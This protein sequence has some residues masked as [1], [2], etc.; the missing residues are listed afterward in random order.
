MSRAGHDPNPQSRQMAD[1]SMVRTLAAQAAAIW[2][3][4][5]PLFARYALPPAARILDVGCGTGEITRRLLLMHPHAT[6]VGIDVLDG[7]L[8]IARRAHADLAPRV[9][10][11]RGDAFHLQYADAS[12]DLVTCRHVIQSVPHPER[13]L[14]ECL[15]VTKHGGWLHVLAEDYG[16]LQFPVDPRSGLDPDE[17]WHAG[18]I[19]YARAVGCDAR[20]GRNAWPWL[21]AL[22]L[23]QLRI[24]HAVV[25]TER[26]PRA[27]FADILV[28]W[29]DGY[30]AI[31]A[32]H[33]LLPLARA[34]ALFDAAIAAVRDPDRYA[35]W[36]VPILSG[37][38]PA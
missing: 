17:L 5:A 13:M 6:A 18:A 15:R 25:D 36:F 26:V 38:R 29:R 12:F 27:T 37:R 35:V 34:H 21:R 33:E 1:E 4:E 30:A 10:F 11:E 31:F 3:Q 24:D 14:A 16:M 23:E 32:E 2:P 20:I 7:P 28:A 22:G 9:S 19:P 8:A